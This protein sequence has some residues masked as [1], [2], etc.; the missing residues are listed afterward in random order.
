MSERLQ[1]YIAEQ[2]GEAEEHP[3]EAQLPLEAQVVRAALRGVFSALAAAMVPDVALQRTLV[4][5]AWGFL[6]DGM[7]R[8]GWW[9]ASIYGCMHHVAAGSGMCRGCL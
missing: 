8:V 1:Q 9:H 7:R 3:P 4:A 6:Q 2:R 5:G